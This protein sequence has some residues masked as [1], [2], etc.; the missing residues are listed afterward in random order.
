MTEGGREIQE[1]RIFWFDMQ[2]VTVADFDAEGYILDIGGG[3]E[4]IIGRLKGEQVI[5]VDPSRRELEEAPPGP[6]K[7][8][9]DATDLQFLDKTFTS[10]TSFFA[11]MYIK[12]FEHQRV[13][14]EVFRVL[15]PGGR[16]LIWDVELPPRLDEHKDVAAFPI[17]VKLPDETVSTGYGVPWPDAEQDLGYYVA[18]VRKVGFEVVEKWEEG[19][20]FF[21]GLRKPAS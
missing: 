6:L 8:V 1:E 5:A 9:M 16:F 2:E 12:G 19:R 18:L 15:K 14:E 11:L 10:A 7:V 13:F 3:G 21:L 20:A 4:G 17:I